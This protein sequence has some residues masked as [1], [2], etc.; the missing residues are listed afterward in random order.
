LVSCKKEKRRAKRGISK[1]ATREG[2]KAAK[3]QDSGKGDRLKKSEVKAARGKRRGNNQPASKQ[4]G[5]R[6]LL[7]VLN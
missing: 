5:V 1:T 3:E 6:I 4:R 7:G 2:Q